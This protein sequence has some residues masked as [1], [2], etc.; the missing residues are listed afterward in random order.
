MKFVLASAATMGVA[1]AFVA[2][3]SFSGAAVAP[4]VSKASTSTHM[5]LSEYKDEL[6][7]TAKAIAGPGELAACGMRGLPVALDQ[8]A[9]RCAE[10]RCLFVIGLDICLGVVPRRGTC[11]RR[12]MHT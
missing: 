4:R 7:Q 1:S 9:L 3:S 8:A 2:P 6:A 12:S 10:C 11:G 5:S